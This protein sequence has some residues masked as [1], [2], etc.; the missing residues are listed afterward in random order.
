MF[1]ILRPYGKER[2]DFVVACILF[3]LTACTNNGKLIIHDASNDADKR[4]VF[5]ISGTPTNL[6]IYIYPNRIVFNSNSFDINEIKI[7]I[8]FN[9]RANAIVYNGSFQNLLITKLSNNP[10]ETIPGDPYGIMK[11][12]TESFNIDIYI[13]P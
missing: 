12:F 13:R 7:S 1:K 9:D 2:L 8:I 10:D 4:R 11:E 3:V 6:K 5:K